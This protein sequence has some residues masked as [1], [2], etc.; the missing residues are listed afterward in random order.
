[1]K[2]EKKTNLRD[3]LENTLQVT[4]EEF[5]TDA[6]V[7]KTDF[8]GPDGGGGPGDQGTSPEHDMYDKLEAWADENNDLDQVYD[9]LNSLADMLVSRGNDKTDIVE[10]LKEKLKVELDTWT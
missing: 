1:M 9:A 7:A 6:F 5:D 8:V 4:E 10:W 2:E 3:L